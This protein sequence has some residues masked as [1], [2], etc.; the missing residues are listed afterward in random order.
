MLVLRDFVD[1]FVR[2]KIRWQRVQ[3]KVRHAVENAIMS[4]VM[5]EGDELVPIVDMTSA[6]LC[7]CL[8]GRPILTTLSRRVQGIGYDSP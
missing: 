8:I 3:R 4:N 1:E 2:T 5:A 7:H 6:L